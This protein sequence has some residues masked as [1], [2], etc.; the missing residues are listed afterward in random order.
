MNRTKN[1]S[2]GAI[3]NKTYSCEGGVCKEYKKS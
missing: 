3:T 1:F 2:T